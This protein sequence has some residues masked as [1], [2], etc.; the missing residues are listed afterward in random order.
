MAEKVDLKKALD[1]YRAKKGK[2]QLFDV[3]PLHVRSGQTL[4]GSTGMS[5]RAL[6]A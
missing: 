4:R 1:T 2:F 6:S 3:P 5:N